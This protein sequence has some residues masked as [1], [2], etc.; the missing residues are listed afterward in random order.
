MD[1]DSEEGCLSLPELAARWIEA[2][3]DN[4]SAEADRLRRFL[5]AHLDARHMTDQP[6][7]LRVGGWDVWIGTIDGE[8]HVTRAQSGSHE[9][10]TEGPPC[11]RN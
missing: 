10:Q 8:R 4:R 3:D 6:H 1:W 2:T 7:A 9:S 11:P 5:F